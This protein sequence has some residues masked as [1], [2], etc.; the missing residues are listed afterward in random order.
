MFECFQWTFL[1][2]KN[3]LFDCVEFRL[4]QKWATWILIKH[5]F[6]Y[7]LDAVIVQNV[8]KVPSWSETTYLKLSNFVKISLFKN[9]RYATTTVELPVLGVAKKF[10]L[11]TKRKS[12]RTGHVW[13]RVVW[14][15]PSI[16]S[17]S[18]SKELERIFQFITWLFLT[19]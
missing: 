6:C 8:E 19:L 16:E 4:D 17:T 13:G 7:S 5:V 12:L 14:K 9:P 18:C 10:S 1:K 2:N 11:L 15:A 3:Y